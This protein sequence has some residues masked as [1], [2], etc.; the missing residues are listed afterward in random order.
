MQISTFTKPLAALGIV[1]ALTLG[2]T[3][4]AA[5]QGTDTTTTQ[6]GSTITFTVECDRAVARHDQAE[7]HIAKW[8]D[9]LDQLGAR[10]DELASKGRAVAA[11]RLTTFI[12]RSQRRLDRVEARMDRLATLISEQCAA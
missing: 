12:D 6:S 5:A 1:G 8:H 9:R 7:E 2:A 3:G 4:L 10:R 11:D